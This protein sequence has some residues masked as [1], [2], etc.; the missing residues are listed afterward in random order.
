MFYRQPELVAKQLEL[1]TQAFPN[2]TRLGAVGMHFWPTIVAKLRSYWCPATMAAALAWACAPRLRR[3][4]A[5]ILKNFLVGGLP[6]GYHARHVVLTGGKLLDDLP[7]R[8]EIERYLMQLLTVEG[9]GDRR[10]RRERLWRAAAGPD[11]LLRV[12]ADI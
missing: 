6:P 5:D 8:G 4:R 9:G 3:R 11:Y 7:Q 12:K 2:S 10:F 1:L